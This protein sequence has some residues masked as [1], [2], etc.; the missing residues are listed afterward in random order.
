[1]K[2][3]LTEWKNA[4]VLRFKKHKNIN[5]T[6]VCFN[7]EPDMYIV[8]TNILTDKKEDLKGYELLRTFKFSEKTLYL[9][10]EYTYI[11]ETT[12]IMMNSLLYHIKTTS[13][14]C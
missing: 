5:K 1:M 14:Q 8:F 12:L 6:I 9:L 3:I 7:D 10:H 4:S 2:Y 13:K 11:S